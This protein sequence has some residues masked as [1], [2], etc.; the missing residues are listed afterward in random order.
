MAAFRL[1]KALSVTEADSDAHRQA[2]RYREEA[3]RVR[4][5]IP[6]VMR[7]EAIEYLRILAERYEKLA[8]QLEPQPE[9]RQ[10]TK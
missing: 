10:R 9:R 8:D 3:S 2:G 7:P 6:W 1:Q 5:L 4:A